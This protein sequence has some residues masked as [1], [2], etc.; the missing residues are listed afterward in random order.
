MWRLVLRVV[1]FRSLN[2]QPA[3]TRCRAVDKDAISWMTLSSDRPLE[4]HV[5]RPVVQAGAKTQPV[6]RLYWNHY[7]CNG[8]PR[9]AERL[10]GEDRLTVSQPR[11]VMTCF[12][13]V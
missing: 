12:M 10:P 13:R 6:F 9:E 7:A 3:L 8:T 4:P 11:L 5:W 2:A 1:S